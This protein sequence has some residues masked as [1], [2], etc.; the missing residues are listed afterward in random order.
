MI[1][2]GFGGSGT[3][4]PQIVLVF[5]SGL[6]GSSVTEALEKNGHLLREQIFS[7]NWPTPTNTQVRA[8]ES[9]FID[10]IEQRPDSQVTIVWAAGR[11]G[12]G[13][14]EEDMAQ[15]FQGFIGVQNL[16]QSLRQS[17][18]PANVRFIHISSAGGL[19]E[20]QVACDQNTLPQPIRAYGHGKLQQETALTE[21]SAI[22]HR[23]IIRPSSVFGYAPQ[24]RLGLI[25]ALISSS[26]QHREAMIFGGLSTQRDFIY[27]PDIGR[28]IAQQVFAPRPEGEGLE[29]VLIASGR[30]ATVFE[31]IKTVESVV[32]VPLYLKIDAQPENALNNTF[33]ISALPS[34]FVPT[35]L[36]QGIEQTKSMMEAHSFGN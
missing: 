1:L 23:L 25:S 34:K 26:I 36:R 35:P 8:I 10:H 12:F 11:S 13:S 30:P 9:A 17:S 21:N 14:S 24:G 22:G 28:Y 5:G 32:G 2:L 19:F 3:T 33:R 6:I 18:R 15:E 4:E 27:A 20:G 29:K 31:I 16:A 7:W